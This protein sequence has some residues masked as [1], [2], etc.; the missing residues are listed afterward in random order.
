LSLAAMRGELRSAALTGRP[1]PAPPCTISA[2]QSF[3]PF[4]MQLG[5]VGIG[6]MGFGMARNLLRAG[7]EVSV[8][9]RTRERAEALV[10]DGATVA[11]SPAAA[12]RGAAAV[13][14][15]LSDDAAL[16]EVSRGKDGILRALEPGAMHVSASTVSTACARAMEVLHEGQGRGFVSACVWGRPAV[17]EAGKLITM[18]AGPAELVEHCRPLLGAFSRAVF[19]AGCEPWQA[20]AAKLCGN[21]MIASM[22]EAFSESFATLRKGGVQPQPFLDAMVELFGS[23]LYANYGK[24]IVEE[25]FEPAGFALKLGLKDAELVLDNARECA[26]P[27]PMASLVRD[28]L[29]AAFTQD[30]GEAD[31]TSVSRVS[32]REAGL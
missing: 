5:F 32:A 9:N 26:S 16:R 25:R 29:L 22:M 3:Y 7:H 23:A 21:F 8:Y 14:T 31:W 18:A 6:R 28:R 17:A 4:F 27:M 15:M 12:C 20:N 30:G 2:A 24:L 10:R 11:D 13:F 1:K 19:I